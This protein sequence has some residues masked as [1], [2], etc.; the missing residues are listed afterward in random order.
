[1]A[2]N[3]SFGMAVE[4]AD[5]VGARLWGELCSPVA[6]LYQLL[7]QVHLLER[8]LRLGR[9]LCF[10]RCGAGD[11]RCR[12]AAPALSRAF[13]EDDLA[14]GMGADRSQPDDSVSLVLL[15]VAPATLPDGDVRASDVCD[16]SAFQ[17][18]LRLRF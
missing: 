3:L 14:R 1:M 10:D 4:G 11:A 2:G 8:R 7:R 12:A 17:E 5:C 13:R 18:H 16:C 6:G 15:L 9:P